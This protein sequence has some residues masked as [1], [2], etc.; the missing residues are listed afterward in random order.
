MT[1]KVLLT[2]GIF[3][4]TESAKQKLLSLEKHGVGKES[5]MTYETI[6]IGLNLSRRQKYCCRLG[7]T[8]KSLWMNWCS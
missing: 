1:L 6:K 4:S 7:G 5:G 8:L 3:S 2:V